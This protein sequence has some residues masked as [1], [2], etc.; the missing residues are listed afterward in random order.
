[1]PFTTFTEI[2]QYMESDWLEHVNLELI[3]ERFNLLKRDIKMELAAT[4]NQVKEVQKQIVRFEGKFDLENSK[5]Y[6][7]D[8]GEYGMN[9]LK[10]WYKGTAKENKLPNRVTRWHVIDKGFEGI[11][12]IGLIELYNDI[13]AINWLKS[14]LPPSVSKPF[15]MEK[16][17]KIVWNGTQK[18]LAE[19]FIELKRKDFI[20]AWNVE[21]LKACFTNSN[22]IEQVLKPIQDAKTKE[23]T[24]EQ[25]YTTKYKAKFYGMKNRKDT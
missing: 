17:E 4:D 24:Y 12:D 25:V 21:T 1:M 19:L 6:F 8:R 18:E 10:N 14:L 7:E 2:E 13:R 15:E 20:D 5:W 11:G 9:Y 22:T 23:D 3:N 16:L